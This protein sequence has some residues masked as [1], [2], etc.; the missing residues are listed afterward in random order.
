M[1]KLDSGKTMILGVDNQKTL[2]N[3]SD[4]SEN[5]LQFK[6]NDVIE[7]MPTKV[8]GNSITLDENSFV[9]KLDDDPNLPNKADLRTKISDVKIDGNYCIEAII[10]KVPERREIQT[11]NGE[12]V[13]L[14]EIFVEDDSGQIWIKGWRNQARVIDKCS[15]G[16]IISVTAVNAR[17]GLEGRV[18]LNLSPFSVISKK[19]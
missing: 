10:L 3:I 11:K 15:I 13:L 17:S 8:F 19:N 7:C 18:E 5:T 1:T 16:E 6:E 9:R 14:S 12:S 4:S 2:L